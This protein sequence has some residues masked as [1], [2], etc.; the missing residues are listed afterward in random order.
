MVVALSY[1]NTASGDLFWD[2]GVSMV[3]ANNFNF[4]RF[5]YSETQVKD[6]VSLSHDRITHYQVDLI[7][8][9]GFQAVLSSKFQITSAAS[10]NELKDLKMDS[11]LIYGLTRAPLSV[12]QGNVAYNPDTKVATLTNLNRPMESDWQVV[13]N[14]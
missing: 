1:D 7:F 12:D 4:I 3:T 10:P 5:S 2:D 14:F 6:S 13:I 8:C 9:C 11:V